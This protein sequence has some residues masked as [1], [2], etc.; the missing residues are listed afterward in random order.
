MSL[1]PH[2]AA[3]LER[4]ARSRDGYRVR[5]SMLPDSLQPAARRLVDAGYLVSDYYDG[6]YILTPAGESALASFHEASEQCARDLS[7]RVAEQ[8]AEN[9]RQIALNRS[10][11]RLEWRRFWLG[12]L[13]GW[14]LGCFT[15]LDLWR[16][17][18]SL[19]HR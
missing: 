15:P 11:E 9:D 17:I 1:S 12:L 16:F 14:V 3:L 6:F 8:R 7:Q 19:F 10:K 2:E 4:V 18:L 5:Y 13:I